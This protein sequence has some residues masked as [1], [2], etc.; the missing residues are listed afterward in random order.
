M[1]KPLA[2]GASVIF[3]EEDEREKRTTFIE[4]RGFESDSE[5]LIYI[6]SE[7]WLQLDVTLSRT[8]IQN[9]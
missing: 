8:A 5:D 2:C 9:F 3:Q 1:V 6:P 7:S 4:L